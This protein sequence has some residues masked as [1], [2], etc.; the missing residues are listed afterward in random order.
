MAVVAS[1]RIGG[2]VER[3]LVKRRLK[4]CL[5]KYIGRICDNTDLVFYARKEISNASFE[6]ICKAIENLLSKAELF[7]N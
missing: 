1:K 7:N 6:E 4:S 2:A 5:V 3:N